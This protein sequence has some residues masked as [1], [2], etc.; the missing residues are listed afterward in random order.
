MRSH[1]PC[2]DRCSCHSAGPSSRPASRTPQTTSPTP[3]SSTWNRTAPALLLA[4]LAAPAIAAPAPPPRP[5]L[6][7]LYPT[8]D[9]RVTDAGQAPDDPSTGWF[10]PQTI[11]VD[12]LVAAGL[13]P[14]FV[15]DPS[16]SAKHLAA[17]SGKHDK[18]TTGAW[19]AADYWELHGKRYGPHTPT[20]DITDDPLPTQTQSA[21]ST[22]ST[23][24]PT[25]SSIPSLLAIESS[26]PTGWSD[27]DYRNSGIYRIPIVISFAV[28]IALMIGFLIG[29]LVYRRAQRRKRR[30]KK[31]QQAADPDNDD[32][33]SEQRLR[34]KTAGKSL[35]ARV[36]RALR[37]SAHNSELRQRL[38]RQHTGDVAPTDAEH[39][40]QEA[41]DTRETA[42][43]TALEQRVKSWARRSAAWRVQARVGMR[44]RI[45]RA[46]RRNPD[47]DEIENDVVPSR[48]PSRPASP[49]QSRTSRTS[50]EEPR[51]PVVIVTHAEPEPAPAVN[52]TPTVPTY[53]SVSGSGTGS[54]PGS[55]TSTSLT[56]STSH[57]AH[58]DATP[59]DEPAY[60]Y[61]SGLP[62]AYR[63]GE[64]MTEVQRGKMP[65]REEREEEEPRAEVRQEERQETARTWTALDAYAFSEESREEGVTAHVATD[66]KQVLERLR[67]MRGAPELEPQTEM[68]DAPMEEDVFTMQD[69]GERL[70]GSSLGMLP[71][72]PE[73]QTRAV[74]REDESVIPEPPAKSGSG[75]VARYGEAD[76]S[77]PR[78]LEGAS[79]SGMV[80]SVEGSNGVFSPSA[81]PEELG[82]SAPEEVG[83]S[84]PP[85]ELGS[86]APSGDFVPSAPPAPSA[87]P[88]DEDEGV[89]APSAPPQSELLK[90]SA[91]PPE[92]EPELPMPQLRHLNSSSPLLED[93]ARR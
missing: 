25:S 32:A 10:A 36:G 51:A 48:A 4:A 49:A 53:S 56:P 15:Y 81:P 89:T 26:L 41:E 27:P 17:V 18:D 33:A 28:V 3:S 20:A 79:G 8:L 66:D 23:S 88:L 72:P 16:A 80:M 50:R 86:L 2:P 64:G 52:V 92:S 58:P 62:P 67:R 83:P 87:P 85:D 69:E 42:D 63:R 1:Y 78:Y 9:K 7:F 68:G 76:L 55:S 91:P 46:Q 71:P 93:D 37:A 90:P 35:S 44:R 34:E 38:T 59:G 22:T 47:T 84:A 11:E 75:P 73:V 5:D 39:G 82:P 54:Q 77:L 60:E 65:M 6:A 19:V 30:R 12:D 24:T 40:E 57:D 29:A 21:T 45:T 61:G 70:G 43:R 14:K 13:S 31:E 74:P